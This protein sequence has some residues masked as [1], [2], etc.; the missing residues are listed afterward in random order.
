[1]TQTR[2]AYS[3][4]AL[5]TLAAAGCAVPHTYQGTDA[6]PPAVT[7]PAGSVIDTSDYYEAHHEGRVYVF[8]DFATYKAFLEYGHTPYR[9][10]R[11]GEGPNGQTLVFGLTD[12]D[13]AKREGIASVALYDG[14]L[15][16]TDP[17]YG[18]VLY[19]G[20]FYVFDRWEDLQ[21]FK[22]T[23]EA[24][25]RFTEIGAGPANRTVVYV[26][27]DDN[28]TRRPEALMARFRSRHQQR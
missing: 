24:P 14:E 21:A 3:L 8:D 9:L 19:D 7:E 11:I 12:E 22:A 13:K 6:M 27:N 18:E 16:G 28:K 26:L 23:W 4:A 5:S 1:M 17:F 2:L 20:R 25:Y 15:S 10:V